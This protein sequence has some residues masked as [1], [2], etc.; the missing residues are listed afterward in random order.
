MQNVKS[1]IYKKKLKKSVDISPFLWY[2]V[3]VIKRDYNTKKFIKRDGEKKN[4]KSGNQKRVG[5]CN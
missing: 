3:Y 1:T 2:N 5:K 4:E